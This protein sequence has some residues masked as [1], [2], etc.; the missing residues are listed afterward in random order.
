MTYLKYPNFTNL[1]QCE[2]NNT[3]SYIAVSSYTCSQILIW[4]VGKKECHT[5]I[6][7]NI[8]PPL[9]MKWK[10]DNILIIGGKYELLL[11][12]LGI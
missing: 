3:G 6:S 1:N 2:W 11:L 5:I 7:E 8:L 10:N 4:N 12:L 9:T